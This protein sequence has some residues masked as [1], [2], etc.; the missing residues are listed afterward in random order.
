VSRLRPGSEAELSEP[1]LLEVLGDHNTEVVLS[2]SLPSRKS[3]E[4][5][6]Y[7]VLA[8][9]QVDVGEG[10]TLCFWKARKAL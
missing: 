9:A 5:R 2:V 10:Q 6:G 1:V 7:E 8:E 4:K 3:Y